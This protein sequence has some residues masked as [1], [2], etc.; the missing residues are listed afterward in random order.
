MKTL[1]LIFS[2]LFSAGAEAQSLD[3]LYKY[4]GEVIDVKISKVSDWTVTF[5][6][7]NETAEQTIGKYAVL[8]II[9]SSGRTEEI[10]PKITV[11]NSKDWNNVIL[12]E[13]LQAVSGLKRV[14]EIRGKTSI[15]GIHTANG[16][17]RKSLKK[18]KSSAAGM[19]AC[20]V[21][22]TTDKDNVLTGQ[23]IKRGVAYSYN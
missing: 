15:M 17:D 21:L 4:S 12:I 1:I 20:F 2:M 5:T 23:A 7:P 9:Y 14:G 16:A 6:Y 3:K 8:K 10:T 18:L 13:S 19:G 22:L 11:K